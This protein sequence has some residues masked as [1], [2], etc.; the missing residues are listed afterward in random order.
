MKSLSITSIIKW[1]VI[2]F[3]FYVCFILYV[4]GEHRIILYAS[5]AVALGGMIWHMLASR[6]AL[7]HLFPIGVLM[8]FVM[9][10]YSLVT[11]VFVAVNPSSLMEAIKSYTAYS[12]MCIAACFVCDEEKSIDW[13]ADTF[14]VLSLVSCF[15]IFRGG[16]YLRGYGYIVSQSQ[17]PNTL[18][19]ILDIGIF[20]AAYR[21]KDNAKSR[22]VYG[23]MALVFIYYIIGC[24]SRKCLLAAGVIC[25]IWLFPLL[26][27]VYRNRTIGQR[28]ML[29]IILGVLTVFVLRYFSRVYVNTE[30]FER[31]QTLGEEASSTSFKR[32]K[33][34]QYAIEYFLEKPVFGIGFAQYAEWFPTHGYSHSTYAEAIANWG[35]VGCMLYFTPIIA[36][37]IQAWII[38]YS[39]RKDMKSFMIFGLCM[40]ELLLGVGQI[41]FYEIEH[42]FVWT[43]IFMFIQL[44]KSYGSMQEK[45]TKQCRYL[46]T[47]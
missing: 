8:N 39:K 47:V 44:E 32:M 28:V 18:G 15:Q 41:F 43:I 24:G 33:Y 35:I 16:F 27:S 5:A 17:N 11:G 25:L 46:R 20:S 7:N 12:L 29:T 36:G 21:C 19:M 2:V 10:V 6:K 23:G 22:L 40:M 13:L 42:L 31:M 45:P 37:T 30:S 3:L 9:C 34:Y 4:F 38:A 14:I 26:V 1:S